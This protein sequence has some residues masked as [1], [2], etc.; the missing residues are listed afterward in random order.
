M[1]MPFC[2]H[3]CFPIF[4][5]HRIKKVLPARLPFEK[6]ILQCSTWKR[7][8]QLDTKCSAERTLF[9]FRIG[10]E[11]VIPSLDHVFCKLAES[12]WL[13]AWWEGSESAEC[14]PA[15]HHGNATAT[16]TATT[17]TLPDAECT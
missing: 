7:A 10:L 9:G 14:T 15:R 13:L 17:S 3:Y 5:V 11:T 1:P 2:H 8:A 16:T 4:E 12:L 6:E